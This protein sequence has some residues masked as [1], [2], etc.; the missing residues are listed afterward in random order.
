MTFKGKK[1]TLIVTGSIAAYKAAELARELVKKEVEVRVIM[2]SSGEQFIT[3]LTMQTITKNPVATEMF[4]LIQESQIGHI[5][6]ADADAIVV[7]PATANIIAKIAT[8][9]A[10]DLASSVLL[11]TK[12]PII[13]APA[14][15]VNM[16]DNPVTQR[17]IDIC[18]SLGIEFVDPEEGELAC[19][20][21]AKGRLADLQKILANIEVAF[22]DGDLKGYHI[23]VTAGPTREPIDPV[24]FVSNRS[25]GKMGY[26]V[27]NAAVQRGARVTLITG[28]TALKPPFKAEV[29]NVVTAEEMKLALNEV[30][31]TARSYDVDKHVLI[32]S[33]AVAD[34]R[35]RDAAWTKRKADKNKG[36]SLEMAP[37]PD[38]LYDFGNAKERIEADL[39]KPLRIVGFA[40]ETGGDTE[41]ISY[42]K[43]KLKAKCCDLM[44][45]N[46]ANEAME[47][48]TNRVF[49]VHK[50]NR[51][52][53]MATAGKDKVAGE[54]LDRVKL[55]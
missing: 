38:I 14:M 42:A 43:S 26:S 24:R 22:G 45:A 2:T 39:E 34:H 49:F 15:N 7:A 48:D 32:M 40:A 16:W 52:E 4:N 46:G 35:P 5:S 37:N 9:L 6:L 23:V 18:R 53:E 11:A 28:P 17:N 20:W 19:G 3:P 47:R 50:D 27:A 54:I 30:F 31:K 10:D 12:A 55:L 33:A 41:I 8:G 29:H 25:S 13:I 21:H 51:V 1:I 44:V 36:F